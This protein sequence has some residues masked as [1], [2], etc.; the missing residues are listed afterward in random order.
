MKPRNTPVEKPV[1]IFTKILYRLMKNRF[2][3]V[4]M[5]AKV[6]YARYPK[7]GMAVKKLNDV[8]N[9]LNEL[10]REEKLMIK[11]SVATLNGCN[12]CM[13]LTKWQIKE[14]NLSQE[15]FENP[16]N[17][18]NNENVSSREKALFEYVKEITLKSEASDQT[19]NQLSEFCSEEEIIEITYLAAAENFMNRL[20]KPLNIGSDNLCQ[21]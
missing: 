10:T 16:L 21:I 11:Q 8:E 20:L 15:K 14:E 6:I 7:I 18:H 19:Y 2:D 17:I 12:F 9:S 13:D 1:S 3:K 4:I 5:P